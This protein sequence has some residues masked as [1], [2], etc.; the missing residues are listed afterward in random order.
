MKTKKLNKKGF[1]LIELLVVISILSLVLSISMYIIIGTLSNARENTYKITI[2]EVE[3]AAESYLKENSDELVFIKGNGNVEYQCVS[4]KDLIDYGFLNNDVTKS[5]IDDE[6]NTIDIDNSIYVER[7]TS[8]KV[9]EKTVYIKNIDDNVQ[10][11]CTYSAA[12]KGNI[13]FSLNPL[14]DWSK[15]KSVDILYTLKNVQD[16]S[17][18]RYE[19]IYSD[20]ENNTINEKSSNNSRENISATKNGN[21]YADIKNISDNSIIVAKN[22]VINKIDNDG[23]IVKLLND[24]ENFKYVDNKVTIPLSI[25]DCEDGNCSG[26]KPYSSDELNNII[27]SGKIVIKSNDNVLNDD[28]VLVKDKDVYNIIIN[29]LDNTGSASIEVA[30]NTFVDSVVDDV[31]N[32]NE[33]IVLHVNWSSVIYNISYNLNNGTHGVDYPNNA[34]YDEIVSISNPRKTITITGDANGTGATIGNSTS[35]NQ[36]FKGWISSSIDTGA[37]TGQSSDQMIDWDGS[38]TRDEYFKNLKQNDNDTV[39]LEANWATE[40]MQLPTVNKNGYVC[41]WYSSPGNTGGSEIGESGANYNLSNNTS[42]DIT[43][44][45]RCTQTTYTLTYN[46]KENGGTTN[47]MSQQYESNSNIDLTKSCTKSGWK[48][49]GWNTDKDAHVGL[50]S[51]SMP[52]SNSTLYAIYKKDIVITFDT[53]GSGETLKH[54]TAGTS[55][56]ALNVSCT[57]YNKTGCNIRT[58]LISEISGKPFYYS[59][60]K[61]DTTYWDKTPNGETHWYQNSPTGSIITENKTFYVVY[62]KHTVTFY[63]NDADKI[64]GS[65]DSSISIS[66]IYTPG[67]SKEPVT[68]CTLTSPSI[69]KSGNTIVGWG[70]SSD[71]TNKEFEV[72]KEIKVTSNGSY[73]AIFYKT[74]KFTFY[75]NGSGATLKHGSNSSLDKL[76]VSCNSYNDRGCSIITPEI[77]GTLNYYSTSKTDTTYF[78]KTPSGETHWWNGYSTGVQKSNKTLYIVYKKHTVT[79]N[80]NGA[81]AIG[82]TSISCVHTPGTSDEPINSCTVVSPSITPGSGYST[83]GWNTSSSATTSTWNVGVAKS[84]SSNSTYYA[85]RKADPPTSYNAYFTKGTSGYWTKSGWSGNQYT[86]TYTGTY[87]ISNIVASNSCALKGW[88]VQETGSLYHYNIDYRDNGRHLTAQWKCDSSLSYNG[89]CYCSKNTDC[90]SANGVEMETQCYNGECRWRKNASSPIWAMCF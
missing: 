20:N 37:K 18:Y 38:S 49:I 72:N 74:L 78:D 68:S 26:L 16:K 8:S 88:Y 9:I 80:K 12:V 73:Y 70:T 6:E 14:N 50:S 21:V 45:A 4:V 52:K 11:I 46:C 75:A 53:N 24:S 55:S 1:T 7:N 17:N 10:N 58:P 57:A 27:S 90:V 5:I 43:V 28:V 36:T 42:T 61:T 69:T 60:S 65:T 2:N 35:K 13:S 40:T 83:V 71:A 89:P 32:G 63:K 29:T 86:L 56:T 82:A 39:T 81:D 67:K 30:A 47:N 76:E 34:I 31:K 87:S 59:T 22:Q 23:P 84:I 54:E 15:S 62:K 64:G 19:Y 3:K 33:N 48:H 77:S 44:Y 79:F 85:I 41:K 66:C 51:Y 25:K